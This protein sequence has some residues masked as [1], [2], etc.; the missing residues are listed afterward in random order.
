MRLRVA[1]VVYTLTQ[2]PTIQRVAFALD[3]TPVEAIGGEGVVV[4]PPVGRAAFQDLAPLR[5]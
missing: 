2:F 4:W 1:Q 5:R 3:G